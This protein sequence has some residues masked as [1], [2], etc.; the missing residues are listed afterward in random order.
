M[1]SSH[2]VQVAEDSKSAS[3]HVPHTAGCLDLSVAESI[4]VAYRELASRTPDA[5]PLLDFS[6][7]PSCT[8]EAFDYLSEHLD[9]FTLHYA[10]LCG[11]EADIRSGD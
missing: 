10:F 8:N 3:S 9:E 2:F 1:S 11:R 5:K 4:I 6:M 7:Y